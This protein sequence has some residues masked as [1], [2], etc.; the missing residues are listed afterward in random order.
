VLSIDNANIT[1][2]GSTLVCSIPFKGMA[3]LIFM[4]PSVVNAETGFS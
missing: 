2:V 4:C 3:Y 1:R